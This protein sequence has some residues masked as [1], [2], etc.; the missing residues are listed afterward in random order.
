VATNVNI[1]STNRLLR[2]LCVPPLIRRQMT[3]RRSAR[4]AA[5]LVGGTLGTP[6]KPHRLG[7]ARPSRSAGNS[8]GC[9]TGCSGIC[10]EILRLEDAK[11]NSRPRI[12]GPHPNTI[13]SRLKQLG[14]IRSSHEPS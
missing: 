7:E 12:L 1:R 6:A 2:A 14:I 5:L 3:A 10:A 13:R 8:C 11:T 4:S 9:R